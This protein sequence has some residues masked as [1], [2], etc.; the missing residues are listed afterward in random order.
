MHL[1]LCVLLMSWHF[2]YE[3]SL[4]ISG[5]NYLNQM[6]PWIRS[7]LNKP[8]CYL[9]STYPFYSFCLFLL[10]SLDQLYLEI[11]SI[12]H[13][14][15]GAHLCI[16]LFVVTIRVTTCSHIHLELILHYFTYKNLTTVHFIWP[17][18]IL[19]ATVYI[20]FLYVINILHCYKSNH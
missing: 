17:F 5:R 19:C 6:Q 20:S 4:F 16:I 8:P 10:S 13:F 18:P 15:F 9:F 1:G 7:G 11:H 12:S 2:W 3:V 14:G